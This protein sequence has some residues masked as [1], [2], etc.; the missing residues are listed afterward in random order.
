MPGSQ[1]APG[2]AGAR[3]SAPVHIAFHNEYSV[4]ARFSLTFAAQWLAYAI[5][6][7][8]F[9]DALA[10]N[11]ARLGA[12]VVCYS[13]IAVDLYGNSFVKGTTPAPKYFSSF[14][15]ILGFLGSSSW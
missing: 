10:G 3:N 5:P 1:T 6:C 12:D 11:C 13:F 15:P 2:R 9:A 8:R 14:W 4:G 7:R